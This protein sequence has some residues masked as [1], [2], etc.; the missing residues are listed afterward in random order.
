MIPHT[1]LF[2]II[3]KYFCRLS[4]NLQIGF[5]KKNVSM[6]IIFLVAL[7]ARGSRLVS[8]CF[9]QME[10]AHPQDTFQSIYQLKLLNCISIKYN[11]VIKLFSDEKYVIVLYQELH[12]YNLMGQGKLTY[13]LSANANILSATLC[14]SHHPRLL[15][16]H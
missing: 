3:T 1:K 9:H 13:P 14:F 10:L 12:S 16:T 7:S 5:S 6:F 2:F 4:A 8:Y 11:L 15:V